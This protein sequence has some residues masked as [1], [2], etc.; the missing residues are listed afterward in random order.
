MHHRNVTIAAIAGV[1]VALLLLPAVPA[2]ATGGPRF[3]MASTPSG[4]TVHARPGGRVIAELP[5][6]TPLGSPTWLWVVAKARH[7]RWGRV[8]L[9]VRPNGRTGW[10]D[11][12]GVRTV[13]TSTWVRA[14]LRSRRIWLMRGSRAL[15]TFSAAIGA[16][17][18]PTPTG[19]FSVTDRVQTG[20]PY[21]PFG[22]YAFGLSGHQ[23]N[24][25]PQWA[26]GDQLAIHGTNDPASIGTPAS[27]G[28]LRVSASALIRLRTSLRLGMPV[29]I[30]RTGRTATRVAR[31]SSLPR[32]P[33][34]RTASVSHPLHTHPAPPPVI[35]AVR[36]KPRGS[37]ALVQKLPH[38]PLPAAPIAEPAAIA[39]RRFTGPAHRPATRTHATPVH[40]PLRRTP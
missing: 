40:A 6:T 11:L 24:L 13:H 18:T 30:M 28:C 34:A 8:V 22:W 29:V 9:P 23:P 1:A 35:A 12:R 19:R 32:L 17:D 27:H 10:I 36:L 38:E 26:G 33:A 31:R 2:K 7:G 25:P 20:D 16:S 37:S 3:L 15:A 5:G 4:A 39:Q 21:G 14:S